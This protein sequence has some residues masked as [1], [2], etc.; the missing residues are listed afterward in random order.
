MGASSGRSEQ[1]LPAA[2]TLPYGVQVVS[3]GSTSAA[4]VGG[5][6][7]SNG[8]ND[9]NCS[10]P[11]VNLTRTTAVSLTS[12][13][14]ALVCL[15]GVS[16][17]VV[18]S[19][20]QSNLSNF[21][22]YVD[23]S[24]TI[25]GCP[26]TPNQSGCAFY[27]SNRYTDYAP[28]WVGSAP[29]NS[30]EL[31]HPNQT[32]YLPQ[33]VAF[34]VV[35]SFNNST[36]VG[37]TYNFTIDLANATPTPVPFNVRPSPVGWTGSATLTLVFDVTAAWT[38][39]LPVGDDN[40]TLVPAVVPTITS[41]RLS[42]SAP[43]CA[44]CAVS[45]SETGLPPGTG[46]SVRLGGALNT[47]TTK[48][49]GFFEPNGTYSYLVGSDNLSFASEGGE[50]TVNGS[51]IAE[52]L[53]FSLVTYTLSFSETGLPSGT[54]WSVTVAGANHSSTTATIS[55]E[56]PNGSYVFAVKS[57]SG[58][59][60]SP[61]NGT[62]PVRG[63]DVTEPLTF[64]SVPPAATFLGLPP[65]EGYAVVAG[66]VVLVAGLSLA[67]FR[68]ARRRSGMAP[69]PLPQIPGPPPSPPPPS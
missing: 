2:A 49:I 40:G 33:D 27:A 6:N 26:P 61:S 3:A 8:S 19:A 47:S 53:L 58:Y 66:V 29:V 41:Y 65:T 57:P 54:N 62:V 69:R 52:T 28:Q 36:V 23:G 67:S 21:T 35:L 45:F 9:S 30:T 68:V 42:G 15:N 12:G 13:S 17:G 5:L 56:E 48:T 38:A 11:S 25:V 18:S 34:Y 51:G 39:L 31:W 44:I 16:S 43:P 1:D 32:G 24:S 37:G 7:F 10:A 22:T 63:H 50:I 60:V 55:L 14:P 4:F 64:V 59:S 46:W 20:W